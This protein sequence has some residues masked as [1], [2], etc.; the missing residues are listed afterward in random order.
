MRRVLN[1]DVAAG[2]GSC[3][4][5]PRAFTEPPR[6][7]SKTRP[8]L[9]RGLLSNCHPYCVPGAGQTAEEQV[10][11]GPATED[12]Y[13]PSLVYSA[14]EAWGRQ[15]HGLSCSGIHRE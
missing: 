15:G 7:S 13:R 8:Y 12:T 9:V 10:G 6:P 11:E 1:A 14:A 3:H 5:R 4:L 2:P